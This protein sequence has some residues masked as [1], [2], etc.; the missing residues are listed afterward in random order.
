MKVSAV[1]GSPRK[2]GVTTTLATEFMQQLAK[3]GADTQ[4]FHLNDMVFKGCQGC[5]GCKARSGSCVLEDDL[6]PALKSLQESDILLFATPV[7]YWDVTG[8]FK[9]FVDRT[10]S[11]VKMDYE[12]NPNPT[13]IE[14][15]KKALLVTSQAAV[16]EKHQDVAQKYAGFFTMYGYEVRTLRAC[17]MGEKGGHS[18]EPYLEQIREIAVE[19]GKGYVLAK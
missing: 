6:T 19:M 16:E 3:N 2:K 18:V 15:G 8:Q 9:T 14:R 10:W 4:F 7:Y 5:Q 17:N 13:Y 1:L 11:L 12:T